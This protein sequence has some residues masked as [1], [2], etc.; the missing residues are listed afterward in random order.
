MTPTAVGRAG[1]SAPPRIGASPGDAAPEAACTIPAAGA[2]SGPSPTQEASTL[3]TQK[4]ASSSHVVEFSD[5]CVVPGQARIL[6]TPLRASDPHIWDPEDNVTP[7]ELPGFWIAPGQARI[8]ISAAAGV[9][10]FAPA[11]FSDVCVVPG[12]ARI[13]ITP[14]RA[15][16]PHI[17]DPE[18]NVTPAE[19][20]GFLI[21]P[22]Q[23]GIIL[24][25]QPA[26]TTPELVTGSL[27][28]KPHV[29][30]KEPDEIW[31]SAHWKPSSRRVLP[32]SP[33]T[34]SHQLADLLYKPVTHQFSRRKEWR[35]SWQLLAQRDFRLYFLGS[36]VSNLGTW[37]QSTAQV[38]IAYQVTHSVFTV[39]L[40]AS[41]QFAGMIAVSPWAAVLPRNFSPR[42]VLV[43]TQF[44]SAIIAGWMAWRY[45]SGSLGV[46]S[47]VFGA[48]GLGSAYALALPV[49]TALVPGL[50]SDADA[51]DAVKMNSVSYNA[52]RA[53]APAL[54]VLLITVAGPYLI[55]AL[56]AISFVVFAMVLRKLRDVA[57]D[58]AL[59]LVLAAIF[60][61]G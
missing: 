26:D 44:A 2:G 18:D 49:Q 6:I 4:P 25:R 41:A 19:F 3:P 35:S 5:V 31:N 56:N 15:S 1:E 24:A 52:G 13:L 20:S 47:L 9:K 7:A 39:G 55:F 38:L 29:D 36:L 58:I 40:I 10:I 30:P 22:G 53:V 12:Q 57:N 23:A 61:A 16:D 43:G 54:C 27:A 17:W 21:I 45:V 34:P 32:P 28:I 11:E 60:S 48:L 59:H 8:V 14:L 50:V 51:T 33:R 42:A 46:H 37:L